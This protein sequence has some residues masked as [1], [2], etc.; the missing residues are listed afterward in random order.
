MA[1]RPRIV[2]PPG[3]VTLSLHGL[4]DRFQGFPGI[5]SQFD[6]AFHGRAGIAEGEG[7]AA[8]SDHHAGLHLP[9]VD[10]QRPSDLV[11]QGQ[12]L[13]FRSR[14]SQ[15]FRDE[16]HAFPDLDGEVGDGGVRGGDAAAFQPF[17][18]LRRGN[19][20]G[21]G[22]QDLAG[23]RRFDL[24][25]DGGDQPGL[26][27]QDNDVRGGR[28][29]DVVK[30][31]ADPPHGEF[32]QG[33]G[34]GCRDGEFQVLD[35]P[36]ET[37]CCRAAHVAGADDCYIHDSQC[38][39]LPRSGCGAGPGPRRSPRAGFPRGGSLRCSPAIP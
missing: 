13:Q 7:R 11:E 10:D 23:E 35:E 16:R 1:L 2:M 15:D 14:V 37:Q 21:H 20:G 4:Q 34:V 24:L 33:C 5:Q 17:F 6:A 22:H 8:G 12:D 32:L 39:S 28:G 26:D 29:G 3:V 19:A 36:G 31:R 30:R 18:H 27:A 38:F 9:L 25:Q